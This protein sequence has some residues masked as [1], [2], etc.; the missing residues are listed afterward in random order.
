MKDSGVEW[1]GEMPE[2]WEIK[3]VKDELENLDYKRMP[4]SG[5]V[6]GQMTEQVFDYY[7]AS[8]VIDKVESYIFDEPLILIGEDGANLL[9]RN[10]PLAFIARGKYWVNK[11][12]KRF[13]TFFMLP[14]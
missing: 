10:S 12:Q 6:R 9:M 4:L 3:R 7:G 14:T 8:G 1:I 2:H 11:A 5:E 13:I